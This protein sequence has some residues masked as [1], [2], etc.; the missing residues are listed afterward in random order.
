MFNFY[1]ERQLIVSTNK[2]I[3]S[4]GLPSAICWP[5]NCPVPY[6]DTSISFNF[7]I[8]WSEDEGDTSEE[9]EEAQVSEVE[10][11]EEVSS[12]QEEEEEEEGVELEPVPPSE[13]VPPA[14]PAPARI[15]QDQSKQ[16]GF[17]QAVSR[18]PYCRIM[19][20][21]LLGWSCHQMKTTCSADLQISS[22]SPNGEMIYF[23]FLF[24]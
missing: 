12:A 22:W 20:E 24:K 8:V 11:E 9:E 5:F 10:S 17:G 14:E 7:V 23:L 19:V 21:F 1:I 16:N 2:C 18:P 6:D 15:V 13:P 4:I 3:I